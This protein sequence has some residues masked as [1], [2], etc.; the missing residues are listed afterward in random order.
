MHA[1]WEAVDNYF[2]GRLIPNDAILQAA[3][4]RANVAG[5]PQ[6]QV[7]PNQGQFLALLATL[8]GAKRVLEIGTL[9]G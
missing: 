9:A 8:V 5:L 6:H 1:M 4:Q 7:A 3:Q 2:E